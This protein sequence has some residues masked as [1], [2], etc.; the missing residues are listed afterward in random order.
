VRPAIAE[1]REDRR[2]VVGAVARICRQ[3]GLG[4][5][6]RDPLAHGGGILDA[7][8]RELAGHDAFQDHQHL[9][10]SDGAGI[11]ARGFEREPERP[12]R[13]ELVEQRALF[14]PLGREIE[15]LR[16]GHDQTLRSR[17]A[18]AAKRRR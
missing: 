10:A 11:E 9:A 3:A 4:E 16:I 6:F 17:T 7:P 2:R 18:G 8:P 5:R 12:A 1:A 14:E 13:G 15:D